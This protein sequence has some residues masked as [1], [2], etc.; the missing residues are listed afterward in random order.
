[1]NNWII[2]TILYALVLGFYNCTKKQAL[3]KNSI[4]EVFAVFSFFSFV[5]TA[6]TSNG[7]LGVDWYIM[8]LILIKA[9]VISG[10]WLIAGYLINKIPI[11]MYAVMMMSKIL[12]TVIMS[13]VFLNEKISLTGFI[14][15]I[16]VIVGLILVNNTEK[17]KKKEISF[18]C[19]CLLF[20]SC[21]LSS[22]SSILDKSIL[23]HINSEQLQFW[24][25]L[26]LTIILM[27]LQLIKSKKINFKIIKNNYWVP[28]MSVAL[29]VADR[30]L[31]MANE[32]PESQVFVITILKQLS[33]IELIILGKILFKEKM[34]TKK[35]LCSL[36]IIVG[37]IFA[38]L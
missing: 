33:T 4:Y 32:I 2:L 12:F 16:I 13:I 7:V 14:G 29:V 17:K 11:S 24:F 36:L 23:L 9:L 6:L 1:M 19:V 26:F 8:P 21:L 10:A 5:I 35:L 28:I 30:L 37:I 20:L 34:I 18:K 22:I 3:K 38:I 27:S 31:F 15:M 25:L